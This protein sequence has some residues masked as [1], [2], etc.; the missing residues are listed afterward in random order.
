[1]TLEVALD[2]LPRQLEFWTLETS[3]LGGLLPRQLEFLTLKIYKLETFVGS[4]PSEI[5]VLDLL[6]VLQVGN[7]VGP[8][9]SAT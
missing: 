7:V 6:K 8:S 4:S 2:P 5:L 3:T 9:P 1:M